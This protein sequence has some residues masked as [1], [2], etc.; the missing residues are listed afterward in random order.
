MKIGV[1]GRFLTKPFTGIGQYTRFLF[2]V[3]ARQNLNDH[4]LIVAPQKFRSNFSRNVEIVILPERF[5][6]SAGMKKTYWEQ[7][8]LPKFFRKHGVDLI[9]FPYPSNPWHGFKKPVIVTVH[10]TIPWMLKEYRRSV[11]TRLYQDRC[12]KAVKKAQHVI[13]VSEASKKDVLTVC[14]VPPEKVTVIHN[15]PAPQFTV[16][17][18][19][20]K[21]KEIL[22]KYAIEST[23]PFF[24][25]VGGY[26]DRKNV[27][28]VVETFMQGVTNGIEA[29]LV[30][31]GGKAVNDLLYDSF[32]ELIKHQ[33]LSNFA[34]KK[35]RVI[36]TGFVEE[37]DL[38]ALY[39][40]SFAFINLSRKEGFNLPLVEALVSGVPVIASDLS[41]HREVVGDYAMFCGVDDQG[42]LLG[43]MKNLLDN[44]LFYEQQKKKSE[45][46][47][48]P[49]SW[50]LTAMRVRDVYRKFMK[51]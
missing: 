39:Q 32:D 8:Q 20:S 26:D 42:T 19:P 3:L 30:L 35:G 16:K 4:F 2:E 49:Y 50:E 51:I 44:P 5:A 47:D 15:A 6:G 28:M 46:Y 9:H 37:G 22:K 29:N 24:L 1:N 14:K 17:I 13:T 12:R 33:N 23:K 25:Y 21:K 18:S 11:S 43:L 34:S 45:N 36:V 31:A 38:P 41:V 7:V 27:K 40:S 48:C 10:D